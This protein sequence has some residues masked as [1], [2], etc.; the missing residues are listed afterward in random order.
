MADRLP[1]L[2]LARRS[3]LLLLSAYLAVRVVAQDCVPGPVALPI[4]NVTLSTGKVRRGIAVSVGSPVQKLALLPKWDNNN[5]FLYG[6]NCEDHDLAN[7]SAKCTTFRGG[8]YDP[9][10]SETRGPSDPGSGPD[11]LPPD[12]W[13]PRTYRPLVDTVRLDGNIS[14]AKVPLASVLDF[15]RWDTE[16]YDPQN[17][18]GLDAGSTLV[19]SLRRDGRIASDA[20]GFYWGLDGV[21]DQD[22]MA[23]SLVL[24]GYD[25]AKTYG[26]GIKL[27][28]SAKK[29][30]STRML[31]SLVDIT[32][33]FPNGTNVSLFPHQNGGDQLRACLM[34]ER[35]ILMDM[36]LKSQFETLLAAVDNNEFGRST[37]I[38]FW[39]IV[40]NP[41]RPM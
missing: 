5:T 15:S 16:G 31:V 12:L 23:G 19:A 39:S 28:M 25:K 41:E 36:P 3:V 40:L 11:G 20:V 1:P 6:R 27:Q 10:V 37:G 38:D 33:N 4:T 21:G 34:P 35:P 30:C 32:L 7:T 9:A 24:G 13:D 2:R 26:N 22:Q 8:V 14:M 18:L 29:D 17:I